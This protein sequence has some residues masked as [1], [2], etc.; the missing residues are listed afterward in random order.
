MSIGDEAM[1]SES[2]RLMDVLL[3]KAV[4]E[5]PLHQLALEALLSTKAII[6]IFPTPLQTMSKSVAHDGWQFARCP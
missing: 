1:K 4:V 5:Q 2:S 6:V 3:V